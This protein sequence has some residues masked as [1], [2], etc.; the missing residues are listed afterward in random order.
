MYIFGR[1]SRQITNL[2]PFR[3]ISSAERVPRVFVV[4]NVQIGEGT[5]KYSFGPN[6]VCRKYEKSPW[7]LLQ[8]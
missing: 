7:H 3:K 6:M 1:I 8:M 2:Q 5:V 4:Y